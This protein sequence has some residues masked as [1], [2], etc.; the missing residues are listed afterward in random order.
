MCYFKLNFMKKI[1]VT[2][3]LLFATVLANAQC[4][5]IIASMID[6]CN[7]TAYEGD[8]EFIVVK[9]GTSSL[10]PAN[11]NIYYGSVNPPSNG[12]GSQKIT[13]TNLTGTYTAAENTFINQLN[14]TAALAGCPNLVATSIPAAGI[15]ANATFLVF[16]PLVSQA[17]DLS[18]FCSSAPIYIVFD[19]YFNV[20][21]GCTGLT[22]AS[23]TANVGFNRCGTFKNY[24]SSA[25]NNN[26]YF[27]IE[28]T[29]CSESVVSYDFTTLDSQANVTPA[30]Y[31]G[32][33]V[34]FD[35]GTTLHSNNGCSNIIIPVTL[36]DF[37][38]SYNNSVA[39]LNWHTATEINTSHFEIERSF[40][41]TNFTKIGT[42]AATG[43]S[44]NTK[45]YEF[46]NT[47][48]DYRNTFYRLKTVD[49][50]G[51]ISYSKIVKINPVR[52]GFSISNIYPKPATD[53][54]TIEWNNISN[55][56]ITLTVLDITGR[57]LKSQIIDGKKGFNKYNL[58]IAVLPHG[59]YI[60]KAVSGENVSTDSFIK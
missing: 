53:K 13:F 1:Y 60:L 32:S 39:N 9:N 48:T 27:S 55:S 50:N 3:A 14:T 41:G 2:L 51:K 18:S 6:A 36:I 43:Y 58:D 57:L 12:T 22:S 24:G 44:S 8:N 29:T 19:T 45:A 5:K 21:N 17:Y 4:P 7:G 10:K 20:N 38:V 40:D 35:N 31:D 16:S 52:S 56:P 23:G 46:L 25:T 26:R 59:K 34:T 49:I 15:P 47:I 11:I 28:T 30:V 54:L 37:Q 42:V 33:F